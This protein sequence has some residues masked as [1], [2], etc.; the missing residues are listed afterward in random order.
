MRARHAL[1]VILALWAAL[2][3]AGLAVA[4]DGPSPV[5]FPPQRLPLRFSHAQHLA[6]GATCV[7]CHARAATSRSALDRLVPGEDACRACHPI[8][9]RAPDKVVAGAP[10]AA[11]VACHPGFD[12]T[13]PL[14]VERVAIPSPNLKFSHA[15]H[16]A[17]ACQRCHGDLAA[18]GV[19]LA[20]RDHLPRMELCLTCH[21]GVQAASACT[22]CHLATPGG[23]I[24][25]EL[26]DGAL[27]PT[28][29]VSGAAHDA[30][31]R[32]NHDQL[33]RS[34]AGSCA[35]CHE[36]RFCADCHLGTVKPMD[37]HPGD[38]V[39]L[40]AIDARRGRPDCSACHRTQTFCVGC[41]ERA[42]LG[43]RGESGFFRAGTSGRFH[44]PGWAA[45]G[46]GPDS[47]A[48]EAQRNLKQCTSCHRDDFCRECHA[49]EPG[50]MGVSPHGPGWV[51][52]ARCEALERK[53]ARLCLRCHIE[54]RSCDG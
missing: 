46:G 15:A 4:S 10:A 6:G 45:P 2:G 13:R 52:S 19:A 40:H 23:R 53:N 54:G 51:R 14:T 7:S 26:P 42:G 1:L 12:P 34:E 11:C 29:G 47:H 37:F 3:A 50:R 18:A 43:V 38:Y 24:R 39:T 32:T 36:E 9:R 22:T 25:T 41:H 49:A 33:A 48:R 44:P 27:V 17:T 30:D 28:G 21:D 20:T 16:A 5:V 8:D 31:F 35:S